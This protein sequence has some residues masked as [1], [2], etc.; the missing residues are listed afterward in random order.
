[1]TA[2]HLFL[3]LIFSF[4]LYAGEKT[5]GTAIVSEVVAVYDGDTFTANIKDYPAIAGERISIRIDGIDTPEMRDNRP[6]IKALAQ[7][8]KQYAVKRLREGKVVELRDMKRD[9]YFRILA[10]VIIDGTDLG[11]ELIQA[12]LAKPY[13]GGKKT[14]WE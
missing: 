14:K 7:E 5:Y 1:M 3:F 8:A 12:G 4:A 6:K 10:T 11:E 9:K 13:D 2:K